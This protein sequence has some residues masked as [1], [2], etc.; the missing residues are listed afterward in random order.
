MVTLQKMLPLLL[1]NNIHDVV[2]M[3]H[4]WEKRWGTVQS[5]IHLVSTFKRLKV[6]QIIPDLNVKWPLRSVLNDRCTRLWFG[7]LREKTSPS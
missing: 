2:T 1:S 6:S 4:S 5:S 3:L 7:S